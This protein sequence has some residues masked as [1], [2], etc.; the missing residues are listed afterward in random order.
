MASFESA[1]PRAFSSASRRRHCSPLQQRAIQTLNLK[2]PA[3]HLGVRHA[4]EAKHIGHV[5]CTRFKRPLPRKTRHG[6]IRR[7]LGLRCLMCL[8]RRLL[9]ANPCFSLMEVPRG[10][11]Q[12]CTQAALLRLQALTPKAR[13]IRTMGA[14][15]ALSRLRQRLRGLL[16]HALHPHALVCAPRTLLTPR[17]ERGPHALMLDRELLLLGFQ[18]PTLLQRLGQRH[19]TAPRSFRT[20]VVPRVF[21]ASANGTS[22]A[23]AQHTP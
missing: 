22:L 7:S 9:T 20:R 11:V 2:R 1:S 15:H 17:S 23:L 14:H 10:C 12:R 6:F 16:E 19:R 8:H 5:Q 21:R 3:I 13:R 18:R 4:V